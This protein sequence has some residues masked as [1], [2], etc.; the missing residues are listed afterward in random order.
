MF[1]DAEA[2]EARFT[3]ALPAQG[4]QVLGQW[5]S[6]VLTEMLPRYVAESLF[7]ARLDL[8]ST[9]FPLLLTCF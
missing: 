6:K 7:F 8:E 2:V 9:F 5:A 3:I 4:R 1:V